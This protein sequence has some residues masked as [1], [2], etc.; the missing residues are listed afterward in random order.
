MT[1]VGLVLGAGGVVGQAYHAGVLAAI[2]TE[3][4]WDP[5]TA[6]ADVNA[7]INILAAGQAV[8]GRGGTS[9][10]PPIGVDQAQRP[11][12]ASTTREL[13]LA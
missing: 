4:G 10:A 9:H 1:S 13:V 8:T 2:E 5:R 6:N 7:A 12:E 11:D 3:L